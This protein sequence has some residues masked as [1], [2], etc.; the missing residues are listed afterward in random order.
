MSDDQTTYLESQIARKKAA[1]LLKIANATT[2]AHERKRVQLRDEAMGIQADSHKFGRFKAEEMEKD[3]ESSALIKGLNGITDKVD[4]YHEEWER[5]LPFY[6]TLQHIRGNTDFIKLVRKIYAWGI[7]ENYYVDA[8]S[9]DALEATGQ[10]GREKLRLFESLSKARSLKRW[11]S[12][13]ANDRPGNGPDLV[14]CWVNVVSGK[15][16]QTWFELL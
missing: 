11:T 5:G 3:Y 1:A 6:L 13:N 9:A 15:A 2:G 16:A 7:L 10:S 4:A 8:V 12:E 14:S